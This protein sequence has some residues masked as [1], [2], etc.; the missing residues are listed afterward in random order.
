MYRRPT[1]CTLHIAVDFLKSLK[2]A[3]VLGGGGGGATWV[4]W[5]FYKPLNVCRG[6]LKG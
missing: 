2:F 3:V 1:L 6:Q 5:K 4:K